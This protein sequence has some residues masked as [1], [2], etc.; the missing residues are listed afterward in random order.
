M[1]PNP[2]VTSALFHGFPSPLPPSI[3]PTSPEYRD[4]DAPQWAV[5][6]IFEEELERVGATRPSSV[7]GAEGITEVYKFIS[8]VCPFHFVME[9]WIERQSEEKLQECI[10]EQEKT[11]ETALAKW[12][13]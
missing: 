1:S 8:E 6:A 7:E 2:S 10:K 3:P 5:M 12:G 13:F 11:I 9:R 4:N